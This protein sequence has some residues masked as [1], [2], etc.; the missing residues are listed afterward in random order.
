MKNTI[1][2][3]FNLIDLGKLGEIDRPHT[4]KT[5]YIA[6]R[7]CS[8]LQEIGYVLIALRPHTGATSQQTDFVV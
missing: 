7:V 4:E 5:I 1:K 3:I 8:S 2:N 6:L